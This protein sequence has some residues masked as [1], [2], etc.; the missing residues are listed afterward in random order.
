MHVSSLQSLSIVLLHLLLLISL[1]L[2]L[3]TLLL[4]SGLYAAEQHFRLQH[5][6]RS[7]GLVLRSLIAVAVLT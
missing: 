3:S 5:L 6:P 7:R 2:L 4:A 1:L